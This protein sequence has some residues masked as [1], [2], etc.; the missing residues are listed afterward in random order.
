MVKIEE[1]DRTSTFAWSHD[2]L[3]LLATGTVA[4]AVDLDFNSSSSLELWD[5]FSA[6]NSKQPIFQATVDNRFYALAWSKP[7]EGKPKGLLAGAFENGTIEFWDVEILIKSKDLNQSSV[8]KS[9]KH[10]GP[11]KSLA[12]NPNQDH[13]MVSGGSK[14]EIFIWDT[15]TFSE[16]TIPGKAMTPMDEISGASWNN[17]VGHIFASTGNSGYTSI[18]DLK[19]KRE[20]L[21]LAYN[22]DLGRANFS[23]V[24]WHPTQSTKLVTAS[25]SDGCP[26][27]LTWDLRN[28]NAPEKIMQGHKKGI[29]SLDWC[30]Q[31]PELLISSGKD[32][33][34]MLWNPITGQK[35]GE[36]PTTANWA[37]LTR[38]APNAPDIFATASF[39]GK[40]IVQSLQ[41]TSPPPTTKVTKNDDEFWNE[42]STTDTQ[43][44]TFEINQAP[45]WLKRPS[46]VSFGFGS[47]L[48]S[49]GK[50]AEGKSS[51]SIKTFITKGNLQGAS[52]SINQALETNNFSDIINENVNKTSDPVDKS[53]WELLKKLSDSDK[54]SLFVD[55][56]KDEDTDSKEKP[57]SEPNGEAKKE[58]N[59]D[60]AAPTT[61]GVSDDAFF[62]KLSDQNQTVDSTTTAAST[63]VPSGSF[64]LFSSSS[65]DADKKLI[66]LVLS[67]KIELAVD[68]CLK[69]DKL[70]EALVL[71]LDS[72][73]N[74]KNKVKDSFFNK[75]KGSELARVLYNVSSKNIT[76]IVGNADVNDWKHIA[77]GISSFCTDTNEFNNKI[78]ELGDRIFNSGSS[79]RD[80]AILCY[81]AGGALDKIA[82]IWLKELPE[83]E[84]KLLSS[85]DNKDI[86][87]P[88]DARFEALNNFAEK[89]A[90]FRSISNITGHLSGPSI[91]PT[92]K[93]ILEYSNL[94]AG[95]GQFELADKFLKLLPDDFAG[96]S[97]DKDRIIKAVT[98]SNGNAGTARTATKT[99]GRSNQYLRSNQPNGLPAQKSNPPVN[100]AQSPVN[101]FSQPANFGAGPVPP[102]NPRVPVAASN[103]Y[104]KPAAPAVAPHNPYTAPHNP[105]MKPQA[106][107][108]SPPST[109][110]PPPTGPAK[111]AYKEVTDGWNDLPEAFK[112]KSAPPRRATAA[113]SSPAATP[114]PS[115]P[116]GPPKRGSTSSPG[117]PP[118]GQAPPPGPPKAPSRTASKASLS[119]A[120]SPRPAASQINSS[121]YAPPPMGTPNLPPKNP[122]APPPSVGTPGSAPINNPYAPPPPPASQA[123]PANN[124]YAPPP[125]SQV[126]PPGPGLSIVSPKTGNSQP[127]K[128]PY[129]PPPAA[130]APPSVA[131]GSR[132]SS[133]GLVPPPKASIQT[134]P[135]PMAPTPSF[136]SMPP[137]PTGPASAAQT[138]P[139]VAQTPPEPEPEKYP[140]GDRSHISG[141]ALPIYQTFSAV[142]ESL[143]PNIPERYAKHGE[144][145]EKR[146]NILYDHLNNDD[147]ISPSGVVS[148]KEIASAL[149]AKDYQ[150]AS[151]AV[152]AFASNHPDEIGNWHTGVKRLVN[153]AEAIQ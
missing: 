15:K 93:A 10:S 80:E 17:S 53:D 58:M 121:R 137:P 115:Q 90:A 113:A 117:A 65:S 66:K 41:D 21:H 70:V 6:T 48:V 83:F 124:P 52:N 94:L 146:L 82:N 1:I 150:T 89:I 145:M 108:A 104:M 34:T 32:N 4:G 16:P 2:C 91:E 49:V 25:E 126:P 143:K 45:K 119:A 107:I 100:L 61:E 109:M 9:E 153:M 40:I 141:D 138:P 51:V 39:D 120:S 142:Y 85:S 118:I 5:I 95:Y 136:N 152:L 110:S 13:I 26:L 35:L 68:E 43:Q 22:G 123:V 72:S 130:A 18:W 23:C 62:D 78:T 103:P 131:P 28:S 86:T 111:P 46:S 64:Q 116:P 102:A 33:N 60:I 73:A 144:D 12:F 38:F 106:P 101:Q 74:V 42:I 44:P 30:K 3:P 67:N 31:D 129:A 55:A 11:V 79:K 7:F 84:K 8:H 105:Y 87:S 135:P 76:D 36:Y 127:I 122:Y 81:L 139:A 37:F 71:A 50:D 132:V 19:S 99:S 75:E 149:E 63:Y 54:K 14:G 125:S 133:G 59:D 151:G 24:A 114:F 140:P 134:P 147:L 97:T 98:P 57:K 148:L 128:N 88:S 92:C 56:I 20:V 112:Q 47:K 96:S 29:L 69:S 77:S 27:L